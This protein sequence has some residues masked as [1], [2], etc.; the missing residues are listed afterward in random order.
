MKGRVYDPLAGR[1]TT[2]DSTIQAPFASQGLNRYSYVFNDPINHTDPSGLDVDFADQRTQFSFAMMGVTAALGSTMLG[3]NIGS[4]A[5]G[6]VLD[7]G[8]MPFVGPAGQ[9]IPAIKQTLAPSNT[10]V[11]SATGRSSQSP[12]AMAQRG[13]VGPKTVRRTAPS[14]VVKIPEVI[15]GSP[16]EPEAPPMQDDIPDVP[17]DDLIGP[18]ENMLS[19]DQRGCPSAFDGSCHRNRHPSMI[20]PANDPGPANPNVWKAVGKEAAE[21]TGIYLRASRAGYRL[22]GK[23]PNLS[24]LRAKASQVLV[25]LR[26]MTRTSICYA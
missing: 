19:P 11:P 22:H 14:G 12:H 13:R 15:A 8:K 24:Q 3:G 7:A 2:P 10:P 6:S 16:P 9:A 4:F 23:I 26:E 5:F 18:D 20:G 25:E 1:F 17:G 21:E